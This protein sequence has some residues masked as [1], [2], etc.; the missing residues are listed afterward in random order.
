MKKAM[1]LF[2]SLFL[3]AGVNAATFDFVAM[4]D[5]PNG[6]PP[7]NSNS[8]GLFTSA[9]NGSLTVTATASANGVAANPYLDASGT[10]GPAGL[11][12]CKTLVNNNCDPGSDDN[13]LS[14][15]ALVLTFSESVTLGLVDFQNGKHKNDFTGSFT[16][17]VFNGG[18]VYTV[19]VLL[20]DMIDFD[21]KGTAFSFLNDSAGDSSSA[22]NQ[23]YIS[24]L[25]AEVPVPAALFLFAPALLGFFGL[26][27]K[28]KL[29]A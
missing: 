6:L 21:V 25:N 11:G 28:A 17:G 29:A 2:V 8:E 16:F 5:A 14:G 13:I 3:S 23:F 7:V 19:G 22:G 27:R 9:T 18:W 12:V 26:R 10:S 1:L 24:S 15:E 20:Q 4:A